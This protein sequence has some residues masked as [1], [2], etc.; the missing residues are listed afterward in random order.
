MTNSEA[1]AVILQRICTSLLQ[2][3][4]SHPPRSSIPAVHRTI[5]AARDPVVPADA[6]GEQ[7]R[8]YSPSAS[9]VGAW[10]IDLTEGKRVF[11]I[12]G[13]ARSLPAFG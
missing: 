9:E 13:H 10:L 11:E 8:H 4:S 7:T 2:C 5:S 3:H 6:P 1:I 12:V